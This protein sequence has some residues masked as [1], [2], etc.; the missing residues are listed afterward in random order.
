[1]EGPRKQILLNIQSMGPSVIA[2]LHAIA[3]NSKLRQDKTTAHHTHTVPNAE[4]YFRTFRRP[5]HN[6]KNA[7]N[8]LVQLFLHDSFVCPLCSGQGLV[9]HCAV[10]VSFDSFGW[11]AVV[12]LRCNSDKNLKRKVS[13]CKLP[14]ELSAD[15]SI[16]KHTR[17]TSAAPLCWHIMMWESLALAVGS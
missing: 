2:D 13:A 1:M 7:S 11:V 15:L 12:F 3:I 8:N 17:P 9:C 4:I 16:V 5:W 6:N 14:S 10:P